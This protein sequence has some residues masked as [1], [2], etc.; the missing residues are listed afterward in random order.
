[1]A[2]LHGLIFACQIFPFETFT[3]H[4][5][6]QAAQGTSVRVILVSLFW[7]NEVPPIGPVLAPGH[8]F[9]CSRFGRKCN[10]ERERPRADRFMIYQKHP[11]IWQSSMAQISKCLLYERRPEILLIRATSAAG[12]GCTSPVTAV[13]PH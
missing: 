9:I 11:T 7:V 10:K 8:R 1:M 12:K 6:L 2:F 4:F 3:T 13:G 5:Y